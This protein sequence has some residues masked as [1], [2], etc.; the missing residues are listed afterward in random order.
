[1]P[2]TIASKKIGKNDPFILP[3]F[4]ERA[5]DERIRQTLL[6]T[7]TDASV[8]PKVAGALL[9]VLLE[10]GCSDA[11]RAAE[12][13]VSLPI[14]AGGN[15][16]QRAILAAK[17]LLEH[18]EDA[19]WDAVWPALKN[20]TAF[21]RTVMESV[22]MRDMH[23]ATIVSRL[24]ESE[25]AKLFVWMAKEY[26]PKRDPKRSG[27]NVGPK[28][29]VRWYRDAVLRAIQNR[30]TKDAITAL[31]FIAKELPEL[32]WIKWVIADARKVT[33]RATWRPLKPREVIDLA[34]RPHS[35]LVQSASQLVEA[36]LDSLNKLQ[37]E[38]QSETPS[39]PSLWNEIAPGVFSPKDENHLSD[40][41][42][43]HLERDLKSRAIIA[44][45]EVEIR[46]GNGSTGERTDIHVTGI[47]P[48]V[49]EGT[50][51]QVRVIIEVK[52]TWNEA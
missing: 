31:R 14:P 1:M 8:K 42:K 35:C 16:R 44:L 40:F 25:A 17:A 9:D 15:R 24:S 47:L 2:Q 5:W 26:P 19:G 29:A 46:R 23:T 18:A 11:K 7:A 4:I 21:G 28:G 27:G 22:A 34:Q 30:G 39:A 50:F 49:V 43:L 51:D 48:G 36:I 20:N 13:M 33:L 10:H 52:G 6:E 37:T 41:I 3:R 12:A 38:L 45:R 32:D